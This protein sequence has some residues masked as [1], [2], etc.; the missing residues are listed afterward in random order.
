MAEEGYSPPVSDAEWQAQI[1][2]MSIKGGRGFGT[3]EA[4]TFVN[5]MFSAMGFGNTDQRISNS[6]RALNINQNTSNPQTHMENM[7]YVFFTRPSLNLSYD[8]I[9]LTRKFTPMLTSDKYSP[10][11]YVRASLDHINSVYAG[12][13]GDSPWVDP[14]NPFIPILSNSIET[15]SGWPNPSIE[16]YTSKAGDMR[17]QW[18]MVDGVYHI[19]GV[20]NLSASFNNPPNDIVAKLFN[21]WTMYQSL[22]YAG[23]IAPYPQPRIQRWID[24]QSRIYR[25]VMDY[26]RTRIMKWASVGV[27]YPTTNNDADAMDFDRSKVYNENSARIDQ[28]FLCTGAEYND[29]ITLYEFNAAVEIMNPSMRPAYRSSRMVKIS[30]GEK[31][32]MNYLAYPYINVITNELEW[33]AF[34]NV[35]EYVKNQLGAMQY[36]NNVLYGYR[37]E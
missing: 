26:S 3:A 9:A 12:G 14:L 33:Y 15:L 25:F 27:C 28:S 2:R 29:P 1:D 32:F 17:E 22:V 18:A 10:Y 5:N 23:D 16:S 30:Q 34:K 11:R 19:Y 20:Y 6:L 7:G 4:E 31:L 35:Y 36:G 21:T 37:Q 8:N 24:Y 13:N